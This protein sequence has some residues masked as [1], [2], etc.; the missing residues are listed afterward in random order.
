MG[1]PRV[2]VVEDEPDIVHVLWDLL[3]DAG[4][5]VFTA[6]SIFGAAALVR[7]LDPCVVLLDLGLPYRPG[8]ILLAELKAD[9]RTMH[10]PV[11]I[12]SGLPESLTEERR[13]QATAVLAKPVDISVLLDAIQ[14]AC[15]P[16][17][18]NGNGNGS[19]HG[20]PAAN[21]NGNGAY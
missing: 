4:Y 20:K 6:D 15:E 2:L 10:V 12:I 7:Q 9:P 5:D 14:K 18:N 11:L 17:A 8:T 19:S 3:S 1:R 16:P 13:A 21:G